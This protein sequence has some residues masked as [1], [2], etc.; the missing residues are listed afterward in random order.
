[1]AESDDQLPKGLV[2]KV[3]NMIVFGNNGGSHHLSVHF[4]NNGGR[5]FDGP[6]R[7]QLIQLEAARIIDFVRRALADD[8]YGEDQLIEKVANRIATVNSRSWAKYR[9]VWRMWADEV[10]ECVKALLAQP[11]R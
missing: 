9:T 6:Y 3:A 7:E 10:I 1:M 11:G 4:G 2:E 8:Q 5:D